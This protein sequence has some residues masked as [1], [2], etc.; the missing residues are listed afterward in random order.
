MCDYE[1]G[2]Y[3]VKN[4]GVILI[5]QRKVHISEGLI[6]FSGTQIHNNYA[7]TLKSKENLVPINFNKSLTYFDDQ[8]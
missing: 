6:N 4:F 8:V 2:H 1:N 3:H 5:S 7:Y